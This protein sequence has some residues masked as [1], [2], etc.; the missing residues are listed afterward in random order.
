M[1][2]HDLMLHFHV[3]SIRQVAPNTKCIHEHLVN[4]TFHISDIRALRWLTSALSG[5]QHAPR[6]GN[7]MLLVRDEQIVRTHW[8]PFPLESIFVLACEL[9]DRVSNS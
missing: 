6:S 1:I 9:A 3:L 8:A 7:L 5:T 2:D 4:S